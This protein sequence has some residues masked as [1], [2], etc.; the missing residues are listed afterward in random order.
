MNCRELIVDEVGDVER[1]LIAI[2]HHKDAVPRLTCNSKTGCIEVQIRTKLCAYFDV[3][4]IDAHLFLY[5]CY[6]ASLV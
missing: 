5:A 3:G 2:L 6:R 4:W 1:S